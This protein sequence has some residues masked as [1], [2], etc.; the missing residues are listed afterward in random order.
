[1]KYVVVTH[2]DADG[3]GSASLYIYFQGSKPLKIVYTEPYLLKN[4]LENIGSGFDKIVLTDLGSNKNHIEDIIKLIDRWVKDGVVIEWYDHHVWDDEWINLLKNAGAKLY[5]DRSTCGVGVVAKYAPRSRSSVD[6]KYVEE[7]VKS[8][9]SGDLFKFDHWLGAWFLRLVRRKDDDD[10]RNKVLEK[11]SNGTIW[12][13]EFTDKVVER[14][15][16]ELKGYKMID[17][18]MVVK[19]INGLSIGVS[20]QIDYIENSFQA[21]YMM[22]RYNIDIAIVTS[23]DGKVSLRSM[24]YDIRELAREFGGGGHP[25]AAGFKIDIPFKIRLKSLIDHKVIQTYVLEAI[26]QKIGGD[27]YLRRI[28]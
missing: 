20:L 10:W 15:E 12:C 5:I 9:C 11:L 18:Y 6:E 2:T 21:A 24:R 23:R 27:G 17:E 14:F 4:T 22:G 26:L 19:N 7:L 25:K 3:V 13:Q 1:M 16:E 28:E 8:I